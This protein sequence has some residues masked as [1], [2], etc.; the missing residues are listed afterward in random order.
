MYDS[1]SFDSYCLPLDKLA[2]HEM[3]LSGEFEA[4]QEKAAQAKGAATVTH[5]SI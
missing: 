5:P 1:C 3:V 2:Y 4:L